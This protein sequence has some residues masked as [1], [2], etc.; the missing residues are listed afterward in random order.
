MRT[1]GLTYSDHIVPSVRNL[2]SWTQTEAI[3]KKTPGR[4]A[5]C[6]WREVGIIPMGFTSAEVRCLL[7]MSPLQLQ[8]AGCPSTGF[9]CHF[10]PE[11]CTRM[12]NCRQD[13]PRYWKAP[14]LCPFVFFPPF[15]KTPSFHYALGTRKLIERYR[16]AGQPPDQDYLQLCL[17]D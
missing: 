2:I 12:T 8:P 1:K 6:L 15:L 17:R 10:I 13:A 4:G 7:A 14:R 3:L 9:S 16:T 5:V 11:K